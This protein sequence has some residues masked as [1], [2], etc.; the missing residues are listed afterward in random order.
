MGSAVSVVEA[1]AHKGLLQCIDTVMCEVCTFSFPF[2]CLELI[3]VQ[4]LHRLLGLVNNEASLESFCPLAW[5]NSRQYLALYW[6]QVHKKLLDWPQITV[7]MH[8]YCHS[9]VRW[10][11]LL[12]FLFICENLSDDD[13]EGKETSALEFLGNLLNHQHKEPWFVKHPL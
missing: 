11:Y 1:A 6:K 4:G 3:Y 7:I 8:W 13:N 10:G 2:P 12:L 5:W 9:T